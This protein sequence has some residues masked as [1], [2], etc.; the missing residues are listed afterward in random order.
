MQNIRNLHF[1]YIFW[2][3][4]RATLDI[5]YCIVDC[6][7]NLF[8]TFFR[9][10]VCAKVESIILVSSMQM[11]GRLLLI[12]LFTISW[13]LCDT[14]TYQQVWFAKY[15]IAAQKDIDCTARL[16]DKCQPMFIIDKCKIMHLEWSYF[17]YG[18][19]FCTNG[20][21]NRITIVHEEK[22]LWVRFIIDLSF[23]KHIGSAVTKGF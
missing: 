14:Q 20:Q 5:A 6:G 21:S 7:C 15:C 11:H 19:F 13:N 18:Y 2:C 8:L 17:N 23:S 4:K 9:S 1:E 16:S 10:T 3:S 12:I 22:D